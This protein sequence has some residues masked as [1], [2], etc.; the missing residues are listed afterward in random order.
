MELA[1]KVAVIT[2]ASR[3][4]G[5]GLAA[6][7]RAR[8]L[9][10]GLCARSEIAP[11]P[12]EVQPG[13]VQSGEVHAALDVR[14]AA[15]VSAFAAEVHERL[16]PID[17]WINNAGVLDPVCFVRDLSPEDLWGHLQ[18]NLIGALNG[19]Q[20]LLRHQAPGAVL[21]NV[22]SGAALKGYAGW[23][24]Y[25]AGK[26]ALDRLSECLALEEPGLRVHSV[27]PGV[28]D[29]DMQRQIREVPEE[30]FPQRERFLQL[31]RDGAFNSP[32]FVAEHFL[33]VAFDPQARSEEV[34]LRTPSEQG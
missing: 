6:V 20:A 3:G 33:R 8:G 32:A 22:S 24:A 25:C 31:K 5:A 26:A 16:G 21:L 29:T 34:V 15:A 4:L 19:A 11:Q 14:E 2:G 12:D 9:R 23:G 28:I 30:R 27:A 1:G 17:L 7:F 10:L 13:E 18:V